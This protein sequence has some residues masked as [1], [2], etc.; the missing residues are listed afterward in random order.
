MVM[1][2]GIWLCLCLCLNS[3]PLS[4]QVVS[5]LDV[6]DEYNIRIVDNL[7]KRYVVCFNKEHVTAWDIDSEIQMTAQ[8]PTNSDIVDVIPFFKERKIGILGFENKKNYFVLKYKIMQLDKEHCVEKFDS[9]S[10]YFGHYLIKYD[11]QDCLFLRKEDRTFDIRTLDNWSLLKHDNKEKLPEYSPPDSSDLWTRKH[12]TERFYISAGIVPKYCGVKVWSLAE[13]KYV[14]SFSGISSVFGI[15]VDNSG[16]LGIFYT[17]AD[18]LSSSGEMKERYNIQVQSLDSG[19]IQSQLIYDDKPDGM[20]FSPVNSQL[21]LIWSSSAR[22]EAILWQRAALPSESGKIIA[23]IKL[24]NSLSLAQK[25]H[26]KNIKQQK[27]KSKR[28]DRNGG[29]LYFIGATFSSDG[30]KI[31]FFTNNMIAFIY[32]A[33]TGKFLESVSIGDRLHP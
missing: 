15:D 22:E 27:Q 6:S 18:S 19:K 1:I 9:D 29:S 25:I 21:V 12:V 20:K 2:L 10:D 31:V 4:A 28:T 16:M 23:G 14:A 5:T 26:L 13:R 7:L 11:N 30:K 8:L 33:E 32:S 3:L 24:S 17:V